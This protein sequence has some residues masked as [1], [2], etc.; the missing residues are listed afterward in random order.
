M[1][2]L[3]DKIATGNT[4]QA[5][6]PR[7]PTEMA[8]QESDAKEGMPGVI[9]RLVAKEK[10]VLQLQKDIAALQAS[11]GRVEDVSSKKPSGEAG[12]NGPNAG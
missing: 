5:L 1:S 10:E 12:L 8:S 2:R 6:S 7:H 4:V 9:Q 3:D 11:K